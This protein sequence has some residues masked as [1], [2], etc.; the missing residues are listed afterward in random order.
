MVMSKTE[1]TPEMHSSTFDAPTSG[2]ANVMRDNSKIESNQHNQTIDQQENNSQSI[3]GNENYTTQGNNSKTLQGEN[4]TQI[5]QETNISIDNIKI[6]VHQDETKSKVKKESTK[7]YFLIDGEIDQ[8]NAATLKA[9]EQLL[10]TKGNNVSIQIVDIDEGSLKFTLQGSKEGLEQLETLFKNGELQELY[11]VPIEDISFTEPNQEKLALTI[12]GDISYT[13]VA[14]LKSAITGTSEK[15]LLIRKIRENQGNKKLN[16][17]G[18]N[19]IAANLSRA[20]LI[21]ANLSDANLIAANL[22]RANLSDANLNGADL[23]AA[24]LSDANLI[25]ANLSRANLSRANFRGAIINENTKLDD[26]W[27]LTWQILNQGIKELNLRGANLIAANLRAADFRGASLIEADLSIA[28]LIEANLRG[29]S[30]IEADLS[31]ANLIEADL[32]GANLR[33]ANLS[34]ANL[35]DA[36]LIEADLRGANLIRANLRNSN[37]RSTKFSSNSLGIS[38]KLKQKLISRGA[39]FEDYLDSPVT[40]VPTRR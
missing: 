2:H 4:N 34:D 39:I 35:S 15:E 10:K 40:L 31:I 30:L 33:G 11:G 12:A 38:E 22:S 14:K 37:V 25:A 9:I 24:N 27:K 1:P 23:I 13:D 5:I 6:E 16:L 28:S 26:K 29:A 3:K 18:A 19:L 36:N 20:N 8:K 32:R 7:L 21:A 17:I